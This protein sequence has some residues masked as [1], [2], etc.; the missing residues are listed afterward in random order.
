MSMA[1]VSAV[2]LWRPSRLRGAV[3]PLFERVEPVAGEAEEVRLPDLQVG[4]LDHGLVDVARED[5]DARGLL[6]RG[7]VLADEAALAG[8][9][10]D[11]PLALELAVRLGDRVAVD[12]QLLGERT[13]GRE[14]LT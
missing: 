2:M 14:R 4:R 13:D 6:Q 7:M 12:A 11:D 8:D 1:G 5:L 3:A 10:L 9:G